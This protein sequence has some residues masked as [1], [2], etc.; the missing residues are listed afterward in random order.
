MQNKE[1]GL[2]K[3]LIDLQIN[4]WYN[5]T[6][7]DINSYVYYIFRTVSSLYLF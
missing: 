2:S 4:N 3:K 7:K 5:M 6:I 1:Q